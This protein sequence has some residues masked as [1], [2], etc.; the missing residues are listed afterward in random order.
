MRGS[1]RALAAAM[2]LCAGFAA[3]PA[4]AQ[5]VPAPS[6]ARGYFDRIPCVD[7]IGRCF[8]ATIGGKAV[9]VIA[10]KAEYEKLKALLAELNDNVREV[11][12]IVREPVDGKVALDVLTR[13][14]AMGLPHVG[15][16]KEEPDVTIYGLDGQ[17]LESE[18]EMV[19]QQ[20]VR[21]NGQPVVTQQET[22]TQDFLP[23]GRYVIAIKYLGRKNWDRKRVFLTVAKP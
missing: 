9:Q 14:N 13:P 7:R 1:L 16:E 2:A 18:T 6:Y 11:Y 8:D 5:Q 20:S 10:D 4:A 17:D 23:P 21:I 12:W 15:E 3:M 19:A 22:L